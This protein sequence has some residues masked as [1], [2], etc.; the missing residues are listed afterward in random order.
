MGRH[1]KMRY[2]ILT[3]KEKLKLAEENMSL[4]HYVAKRFLSTGIDYNEL[5][6]IGLVGYAKALNTFEYNKNTK[7]STYAIKCITNE[8][9]IFLKNENKRVPTVS[10]SSVISTDKNGNELN[11]EDVLD[12]N[13][14]N[15]NMVYDQVEEKILLNEDIKLLYE[16]INELDE[17][18]RTFIIL[19]Y[20]L[21]DNK[22]RTQKEIGEV[23]NL[24]QAQI[25]KLQNIV[26]NKLRRIFANK[27]LSSKKE[28]NIIL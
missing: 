22:V 5:V 14:D 25:S 28:Q 13:G 4:V 9:L 16:A 18:E 21:F 1:K 23:L 15:S 11:I 7:F 19:K 20:G 10:L 8:I 26:L 24:S 12:E 2:N 3:E 27:S 6:S 17:D